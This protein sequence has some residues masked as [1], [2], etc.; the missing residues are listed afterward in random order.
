MLK[1]NCNDRGHHYTD[2][3]AQLASALSVDST[4]I[5]VRPSRGSR[6]YCLAGLRSAVA[7]ELLEFTSL[8]QATRAFGLCSGTLMKLRRREVSRRCRANR[9]RHGYSS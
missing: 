1:V 8:L 2:V 7:G 4:R 5:L 9:P 3:M 6:R